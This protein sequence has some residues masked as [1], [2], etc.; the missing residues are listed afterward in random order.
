M[1]FCPFAKPPPVPR[2]PHYRHDQGI[3]AKRLP[4]RVLPYRR[5]NVRLAN[6]GRMRLLAGFI[7]AATLASASTVHAE[8]WRDKSGQPVPD[9]AERKSKD[10][11]GGWLLVTS[12]P[13]WAAKWDTPADVAP[14]F[15][16]ASSSRVGE[17]VFVL[18]F[19]SGPLLTP[20]GRAE[21]GC[22]I[23]VIRPDGTHSVDAP[24]VSCFSGVIGGPTSSVYLSP[25]FLAFVGERGDKL[26]IWKVEVDLKDRVRGTELPLRTSF[27]LR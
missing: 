14:Q 1:D 20:D 8:G 2:W 9:T 5:A 25:Q 22:D 6:C 12:D 26:G 21:L 10:G 19:F 24:D 18:I 4:W 23:R 27:E 13:D 16:T 3:G 7:L 15:T 17:R 11:F